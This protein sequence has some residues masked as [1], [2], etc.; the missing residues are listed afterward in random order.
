MDDTS[1]KKERNRNN[2]W[3]ILCRRQ[4]SSN[5]G[6][7]L[8]PCH[9]PWLT[10]LES[11]HWL[12]KLKQHA[13][14]ECKRALSPA[15][16][17]LEDTSHQT[18]PKFDP[19]DASL[20]KGEYKLDKTNRPKSDAGHAPLR[21]ANGSTNKTILYWWFR[22]FYLYSTPSGSI[23]ATAKWKPAARTRLSFFLIAARAV[24]R[25]VKTETYGYVCKCTSV[26]LTD[27]I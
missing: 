19:G 11:Q 20:L 1:K 7:G 9:A 5:W 17:V 4:Q 24:S 10:P 6:R 21:F 13:T 22:S 26:I 2:N 12:T 15:R 25:P 16:H 18:R 27:P 3:K 8:H 14:H 23:H